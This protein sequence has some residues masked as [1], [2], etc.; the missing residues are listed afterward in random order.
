MRFSSLKKK[1]GSSSISYLTIDTHELKIQKR[2]Q[3]RF[4]PGGS[5]LSGKITRGSLILA[6]SASMDPT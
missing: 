4:L 2:G 3:L 1:N 6:L 5:R